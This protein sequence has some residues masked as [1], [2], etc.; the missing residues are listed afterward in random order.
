M[1]NFRDI[2]VQFLN[3]FL[4]AEKLLKNAR[5]GQADIVRLRKGL[6][7]KQERNYET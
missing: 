7:G 5:H 2:N 1:R 3:L 6:R 4:I